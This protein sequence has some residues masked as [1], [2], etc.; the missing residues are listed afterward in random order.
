MFISEM[1]FNLKREGE[2]YTDENHE[3]WLCSIC[4]PCYKS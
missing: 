4:Y 2:N 3:K 1:K